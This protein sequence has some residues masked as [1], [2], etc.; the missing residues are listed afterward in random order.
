MAVCIST[1]LHNESEQICLE[2]EG[3]VVA[4]HKEAY[5]AMILFTLKNA[6]KLTPHKVYVVTSDGFCNQKMVTEVFDLP[7]ACYMSNQ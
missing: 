5:Q 1:S 7:N 6:K 4:E 3:I 2:D